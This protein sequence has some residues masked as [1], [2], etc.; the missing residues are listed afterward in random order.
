MTF[1]P[2][3]SSNSAIDDGEMISSK[4]SL[5]HKLIGV[6]QKRFLETAQSRASRNQFANRFSFTNDGTLKFPQWVQQTNR[7]FEATLTTKYLN[8]A[9]QNSEFNH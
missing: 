3:S 1:T 6:P 2:D 4:S 8:P 9:H 5:T 7:F